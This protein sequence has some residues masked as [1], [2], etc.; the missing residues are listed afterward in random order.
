M[1]DIS[2]M[3]N[4]ATP[5]LAGYRRYAVSLMLALFVLATAFQA[6]VDYGH[7][8]FTA[9]LFFRMHG[10]ELDRL[11]AMVGFERAGFPGLALGL[12]AGVAGA[13]GVWLGGQIVDRISRGDLRAFG[14]LPAV[15]ALITVPICIIAMLVPDAGL[16][17]L[18]LAVPSL[19]YSMW[20]GPVHTARQG[21]SPPNMRAMATALML[22][23]PGLALVRLRWDWQATGSSTPGIW[24]RPVACNGR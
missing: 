19:F 17:L 20:F 21:V 11:G 15:A 5:Q 9:S 12:T 18:L 22:L 24:G 2:D 13:M 1:T 23:M 6:F 8:P 14:T 16:A 4:P 10:G 7:A 3:G